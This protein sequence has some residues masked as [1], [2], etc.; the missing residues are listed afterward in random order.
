MK[1]QRNRTVASAASIAM[2]A[3]VLTSASAGAATLA[4][5]DSWSDST[6]ADG[7]D[8]DFSTALVTTTIT[9]TA[10]RDIVTNRGST[11]ET[12]GTLVGAVSDTQAL[13]MNKP[14]GSILEINVENNSGATLTFGQLHFDGVFT[15]DS[16]RDFDVVFVNVTAAT[17][18]A[19]LGSGSITTDTND[20]GF[21]ADYDDFDVDVSSISL[22]DGE[23]GYFQITFDGGQPTGAAI[24]SASTIDSVAVTL[25]P[26]PSSA[27]LLGLACLGMTSRRR[28]I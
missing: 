3:I 7:L 18:S 11:D 22:N 24:N 16:I 13:R 6:T 20:V 23:V 19:S 27:V 25:I 28:R 1:K 12:F 17:T 15:G 21:V 9:G 26:E 8:S 14:D 4:S 2:T 5:W 10:V